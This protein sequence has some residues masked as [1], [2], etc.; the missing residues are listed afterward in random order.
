MVK[1]LVFRYWRTQSIWLVLA[2]SAISFGVI[3]WRSVKGQ[4]VLKGS[5]YELAI[6]EARVTADGGV[7]RSEA[8]ELI[9][10]V[11][12]D[13]A[14]VIDSV[15]WP[16]RDSIELD[17]E[18]ERAML[19]APSGGEDEERYLK[20]GNLGLELGLINQA[21][22]N[23]RKVCSLAA[24]LALD[25]DARGMAPTSVAK[26][27]SFLVTMEAAFQCIQALKDK[28]RLEASLVLGVRIQS[29]ESSRASLVA[30]WQ[31]QE[32]TRFRRGLRSG[33]VVLGPEGIE[34]IPNE[35][36]SEIGELLFREGE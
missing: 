18:D 26:M 4:V 3:G 35:R 36:L 17:M 14:W 21:E 6:L 32:G 28:G 9:F 10:G 8:S 20:L 34:P 2:A 33:Q 24:Q 13:C 30:L 22:S 31:Q 11:V 5:V 7:P 1:S 25:A 29:M 12:S 23:L 16:G 27:E 15:L 19:L